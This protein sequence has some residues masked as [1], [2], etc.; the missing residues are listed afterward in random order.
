MTTG[1]APQ[2]NMSTSKRMKE[3]R[4]KLQPGKIYPLAEAIAAVKETSKVKFDASVEIHA[5]LAIDPKKGEQLVRSTVDLPYGSG[6]QL[7]LA[8]FV[9]DDQVA[10]AKAAGADVA[11]HTDLIEEIKKTGKC[12]F[13]VAVATPGVMKDLA[14]IARILGQKGLMPNPKSGT[15]A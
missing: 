2:N 13:D 1:Q 14:S 6:K 12:D 3:A 11:G 7:R 5:F 10:K 8:A 15:I 4:A 9:T